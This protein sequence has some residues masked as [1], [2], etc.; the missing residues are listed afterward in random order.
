[1]E[2]RG[3]GRSGV[4]QFL[5]A[6]AVLLDLLDRVFVLW[7]GHVHHELLLALNAPAELSNNR[8]RGGHLTGEQVPGGF[9]RVEA[10]RAGFETGISPCA[11]RYAGS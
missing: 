5:D 3:S 2:G 10:F 6:I 1:M 4:T 11:S 8:L 7:R 9:A